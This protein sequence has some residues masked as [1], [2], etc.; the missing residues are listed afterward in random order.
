MGSVEESTVN[1]ETFCCVVYSRS[2]FWPL[3]RLS[4]VGCELTDYFKAH[5]ITCDMAIA[6]CSYVV[7]H[8]CIL[9]EKIPFCILPSHKFR[10]SFLCSVCCFPCFY[11]LF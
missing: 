9:E 6:T 4:E 5:Y 7:P 11:Q 8:C 1:H 3:Q 10:K 2:Y